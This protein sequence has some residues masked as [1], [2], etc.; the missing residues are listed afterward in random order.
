MRHTARYSI[1]RLRAELRA[2]GYRMG[3]YALRT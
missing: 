1:R 2:E 3:R